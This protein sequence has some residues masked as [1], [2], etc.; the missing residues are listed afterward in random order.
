MMQR[1]RKPSTIHVNTSFLFC[2]I[3]ISSLKVQVTCGYG[4]KIE[5]D[6]LG[7]YIGNLRELVPSLLSHCDVSLKIW[8]AIGDVCMTFFSYI[9]VLVMFH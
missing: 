8:F 3:A 2:I 1:K 6:I 9:T 4:I 7:F 5:V